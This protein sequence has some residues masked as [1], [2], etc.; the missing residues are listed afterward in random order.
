MM[1]TYDD[2]EP[3]TK[4]PREE[5]ADT[6]THEA[7][8]HL[9]PIQAKA[10]HYFN[11][12]SNRACDL[13][14][15][16]VSDRTFDLCLTALRSLNQD[17]CPDYFFP[18]FGT[19]TPV[20]LSPLPEYPDCNVMSMPLWQLPAVFRYIPKKFHIELVK[21]RYGIDI[22]EILIRPTEG[23]SLVYFDFP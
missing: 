8:R 14:Y 22:R 13:S 10:D 17:P 3:K 7:E 6:V 18:L 19:G 5:I 11:A 12:V 23:G 20:V 2:N 4:R 21:V 15:V 16:P 1:E 9:D